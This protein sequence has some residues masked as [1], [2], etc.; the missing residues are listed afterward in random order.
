MIA[1]IVAL[2]SCLACSV[3]ASID[4]ADS[5][6]VLAYEATQP[7]PEPTTPPEPN[8]AGARP[9]PA[10]ELSIY[11]QLI[12]DHRKR[13]ERAAKY[14]V[15]LD[16]GTCL[17]AYRLIR[18]IELREN[19]KVVRREE[20][21]EALGALK[22]TGVAP[23]GPGNQIAKYDML[24]NW[25]EYREFCYVFGPGHDMAGFGSATTAASD[26]LVWL[27]T[28]RVYRNG[29]VVSFGSYTDVYI[30]GMT[31]SFAVPRRLEESILLAPSAPAAEGQHPELKVFRVVGRQPSPQQLAEY[32]FQKKRPLIEYEIP[33]LIFHQPTK[34]RKVDK[35]LG[36][37]ET[38]YDPE[39]P[40]IHTY[41]WVK[42]EFMLRL[43]PPKKPTPSGS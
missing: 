20:M 35:G 39:G 6:R 9:A 31:K 25:V 21:L 12:D 34:A 22:E 26:G 19:E 7:Q 17:N 4:L 10:S 11:A 37:K 1:C 29:L 24:P 16:D 32:L 18:S 27:S 41:K 14:Y 38:V 42:R 2:V 15:R 3:A 23:P 5:G 40:P 30:A 28:G 43:S 13:V 8:P 33:Q 36:W